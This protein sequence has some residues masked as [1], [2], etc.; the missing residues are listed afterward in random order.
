MLA[1]S[2][3]LTV[4]TWTSAKPSSLSFGGRRPAPTGGDDIRMAGPTQGS[5]EAGRVIVPRAGEQSRLAVLGGNRLCR[6]VSRQTDTRGR[7]QGRGDDPES[8]RCDCA[9]GAA[10]WLRSAATTPRRSTRRLRLEGNA[11]CPGGTTNA[12]R[13]RRTSRGA[14]TS[15]S[16]GSKFASGRTFHGLASARISSSFGALPPVSGPFLVTPL[17]IGFAKSGAARPGVVAVGVVVND[18]RMTYLDGG[19]CLRPVPCCSDPRGMLTSK[20]ASTW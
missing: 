11:T 20:L 4:S 8:R 5:T 19:P 13:L 1:G 3:R 9:G 18:V 16:S 14:R 7:R 17:I 2:H 6:G 12:P 15:T 10:F